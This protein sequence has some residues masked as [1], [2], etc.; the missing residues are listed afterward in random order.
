MRRKFRVSS[1]VQTVCIKYTAEFDISAK[2]SLIL[3]FALKKKFFFL[4]QH[5][6]PLHCDKIVSYPDSQRD[7][8]V[9]VK[10]VLLSTLVFGA[11]V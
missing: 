10:L 3:A 2:I 5:S 4:N 11:K 8:V 7:K 1:S 9:S 6:E